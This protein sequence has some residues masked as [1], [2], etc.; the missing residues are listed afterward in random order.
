LSP[1]AGGMPS[2]R[3]RLSSGSHGFDG[4][5]SAG[6]GSWR[7]REA[8]SARGGGS[9]GDGYA[10]EERDEEAGADGN[11][12][13]DNPNGSLSDADMSRSI[14]GRS[15][16]PSPPSFREDSGT[17]LGAE[18]V[19]ATLSGL[20]L[21]EEGKKP[22]DTSD[23]H[24]NTADTDPSTITK[25]G[26]TAARPPGLEND[27]SNVSWSYRDPKGNIQGILTHRSKFK[28]LTSP[29]TRSIYSYSDAEVV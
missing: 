24:T 23:V 8:D 10:V 13:S 12:S 19:T 22:T 5:T 1:T 4:S 11:T 27:P 14:S 9:L 20:A 25:S 15:M 28:L 6:D 17:R 26:I 29:I 18:A 21:Q 3:N 2:P 16:A 7:K